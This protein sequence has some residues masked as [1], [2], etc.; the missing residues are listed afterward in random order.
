MLVLDSRICERLRLTEVK[1]D[2]LLV[3]SGRKSELFDDALSWMMY[4]ISLLLLLGGK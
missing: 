1:L 3:Y 2:A 4:F